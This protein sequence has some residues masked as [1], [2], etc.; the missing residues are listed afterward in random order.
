MKK[1]PLSHEVRME[2]VSDVADLFLAGAAKEAEIKKVQNS[3]GTLT[4]AA[5]DIYNEIYDDIEGILTDVLGEETDA[6]QLG[7]ESDEYRTLDAKTIKAF[8]KAVVTEYSAEPTPR[9]RGVRPGAASAI[10]TIE[11]TVTE[12]AGE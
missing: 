4:D 6:E 1:I 8:A 7:H 2:I 5:Q 3:D 11:R 12:I 9:G 10:V